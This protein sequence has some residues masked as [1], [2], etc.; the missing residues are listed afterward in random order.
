[1]GPGLPIGDGDPRPLRLR[2]L[3]L[4]FSSFG[5]QLETTLPAIMR[6]RPLEDELLP[7]Q[8]TENAAQALLGDAQNAEQLA[9]GHLR[10]ASDEVDDAMMGAAKT[11]S[12]K[13][14]VGLCGEVAV[15]KEQQLDALSYLFLFEEIRV[16]EG[17]YVS[18][19][20]LIRNL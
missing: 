16:G 19:V 17:F 14:R 11:I 20:D 13:D 8:L 10:V 1:L 15:S 9:D 18:H 12:R 6:T 7:N 2:Q 5:R 4:E 3:P